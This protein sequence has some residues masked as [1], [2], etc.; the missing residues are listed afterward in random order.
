LILVHDGAILCDPV[1]VRDWGGALPAGTLRSVFLH[2][3]AGDY[4]TT[5]PAYHFCLSGA[6]DVRI[7]ATRDLR[8]N[9]RDVRTCASASA[10]A[11]HTQGRNS[12][13]A[14]IAICA[15]G[16]AT[17]HNFGAYPLTDA[18]IDA[19]CVVTARLVQ[20]YRIPIAAVRTHAEAAFEDGYFGCAD[21]DVRW[22]IARLEPAAGQLAAAEAAS[23]GN[24]LRSRIR[25]LC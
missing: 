10:Y 22:D 13:A 25:E 4:T 23:A 18:Q 7:N 21:D 19:L 9:M 16:G 3:T 6:T 15:M 11:A 14:G 2:W 24:R 1:P 5:F 8:A 17:P 20:Y 12:F